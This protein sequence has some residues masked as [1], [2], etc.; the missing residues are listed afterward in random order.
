MSAE[1]RNADDADERLSRVSAD[2]QTGLDG[3]KKLEAAFAK[4]CA[5][6]QEGQPITI[7]TDQ[8]RLVNAQIFLTMKGNRPGLTIQQRFCC[9]ST[10]YDCHDM[11]EP[12]THVLGKRRGSL[13]TVVVL[14]FRNPL[15]TK[16]RPIKDKKLVIKADNEWH[17]NQLEEGLTAVWLKGKASKFSVKV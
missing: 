2:F 11:K 12:V 8:K 4:F 9:G 14:S 16:E 13:I 1:D 5:D 7:I 6:F 17:K 10:H 15:S 3:P